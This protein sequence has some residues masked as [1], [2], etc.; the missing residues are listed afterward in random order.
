MQY[1]HGIQF[2]R[3]FAT[4]PR[5]GGSEVT[6]ASLSQ[7]ATYQSNH[8]KIKAVPLSALPKNTSKL[9][10]LSSHYPF[11]AER[12]AVPLKLLTS[13]IRNYFTSDKQGRPDDPTS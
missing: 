4:L 2:A 6:L 11:N 1:L 9:T 7:A 8:S 12:Q 5:S 3:L 13:R 10:G